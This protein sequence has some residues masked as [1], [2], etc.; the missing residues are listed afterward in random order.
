MFEL[1]CKQPVYFHIN[2][3][4]FIICSLIV[5][6]LCLLP[7]RRQSYLK[8]SVSLPALPLTGNPRFPATSDQLLTVA[9]LALIIWLYGLPQLPKE[10]VESAQ[11]TPTDDNTANIVSAWVGMLIP[12]FLYMPLIIKYICSHFC[13]PRLSLK[14]IC[15]VFVG[16]GII[17]TASNLLDKTGFFHWLIDITGTP[18]EQSS[19][20]Y[21]KENAYKAVI[22]PTALSVIVVA[23]IVEE[24]FFRGFIFSTLNQRVSTPIAAVFSGILFGSIHFS[25]AQT[26]ILSIFGVVQCYLYRHTGS[27]L[28]PILLHFIFN[29]LAFITIINM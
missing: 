26:I 10:A 15:Y 14:S 21:I 20:Q 6:A 23:P 24:L 12:V 8:G 29:S 9:Y 2:F 4:L 1:F 19:V 18:A 27:I 5:F 22:I 17:Y 16:L 3:W 13:I 7:S 11:N 25:L 28:Y